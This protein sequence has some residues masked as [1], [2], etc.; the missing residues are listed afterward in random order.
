MDQMSGGSLW[1]HVCYDGRI[2]ETF[3]RHIFSQLL[4]GIEYVH[5]AGFAHR[6]I[7]P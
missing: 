3:A 4:D 6:D 1:D 2:S 7:K 5:K